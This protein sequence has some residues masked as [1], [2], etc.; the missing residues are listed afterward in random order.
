ML[1]G[2]DPRLIRAAGRFQWSSQR[3]RIAQAVLNDGAR[4]SDVARAEGVAEKTVRNWLAL[5]RRDLHTQAI[6]ECDLSAF[7][8]DCRYEEDPMTVDEHS[9]SLRIVLDYEAE[10]ETCKEAVLAVGAY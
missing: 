10:F 1:Q 3:V 9:M 8:V 5:V 7:Q 2:L 4:I 6:I